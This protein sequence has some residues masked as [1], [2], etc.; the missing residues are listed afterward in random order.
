MLLLQPKYISHLHS[1]ILKLLLHLINIFRLKDLHV[2]IKKW[3]LLKS[4][5][6]CILMSLNKF[7]EYVGLNLFVNISVG[8]FS[9]H[10]LG[11]LQ[12]SLLTHRFSLL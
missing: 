4:T 3:Y 6:S 12:L 11:S 1:T 8:Y 9:N 5:L 10:I 2:L 7:K